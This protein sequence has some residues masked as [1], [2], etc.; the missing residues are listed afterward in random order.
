MKIHHLL[1]IS[2]LVFQGTLAGKITAPKKVRGLVCPTTL[3]IV[4]M[5]Q[6]TQAQQRRY[7]SM[8]N[9]HEFAYNGTHWLYMNDI[10]E[11]LT[12][13]NI[14]EFPMRFYY[15]RYDSNHLRIMCHYRILRNPQDI[16]IISANQLRI[17]PHKRMWHRQNIDSFVCGPFYDSGARRTSCNFFFL[18]KRQP[19]V[20]ITGAN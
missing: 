20:E 2:L 5:I 16:V 15:V 13:S 17:D 11:S 19:V 10:D 4:S 14:S 6:S 18:D 7:L 9:K 1:I 3:S 12:K 8:Q